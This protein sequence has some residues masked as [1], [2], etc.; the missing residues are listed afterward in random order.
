M[1]QIKILVGQLPVCFDI[2]YN[3]LGEIISSLCMEKL[4]YCNTVWGIL[5]TYRVFTTNRSTTGNLY[6]ILSRHLP[7]YSIYT[8]FNSISVS[9]YIKSIFFPLPSSQP[10][11]Y[12]CHIFG[13]RLI[14]ITIYHK[15]KRK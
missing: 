4:I 11:C 12:I 1:Y 10:N 3:Y 14:T 9:T 6:I 15:H 8:N 2:N 7:R 13:H 5:S